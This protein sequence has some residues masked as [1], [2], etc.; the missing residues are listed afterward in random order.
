MR[1]V[2]TL[3]LFSVFALLF[4]LAAESVPPHEC[5]SWM[6]FPDMTG[7]NTV[8]L[9]K[10]RDSQSRNVKVRL[11]ND[12][13]KR[14]WIGMGG[15][16]GYCMAVNSS[17]LAGVMN[18]GEKCTDN[19]TN[20]N[21]KS[22]PLILE[23]IISTCDTS[24]QAVDKLID[25][26]KKEDYQHGDKGSIF[27]FADPKEGYLVEC[28][29]HFWQVQ[30]CNTG[31]VARANI[32]HLPGLEKYALT[33]YYTHA[34]ESAR[35]YAVRKAL[36]EAFTARGKVDVMD[37]LALSRK[38]DTD[39]LFIRRSLCCSWTNSASTFV[40]DRDYPEVLTTAYLL[41]GCPRHTVLLPLP[42]CI[43]ELPE[44]MAT[45]KLSSAS[46]KRMN[47]DGVRADVPVEWL[48]FEEKSIA[49]YKKDLAA[50]KELMKKGKK[51]EA[52]KLLNDSFSK[53]WKDAKELPGLLK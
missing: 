29:A 38:V 48:K 22:T 12:G 3:C 24:A 7:E 5:T 30:K 6:I 15:D 39:N 19:S 18:G 40:V 35:E 16:K 49:A 37:I 28:T 21:G 4:S 46:Y 31:Y 14:N 47:K 23:A 41:V 34:V 45:V 8:I 44:E 42:I 1:S 32:W 36:N 50:A 10:S 27:F 51:S 2:K 11:G 20:K 53:I 13:A 26:L 17:G 9:H 25:F 43:K 52:V 33:D